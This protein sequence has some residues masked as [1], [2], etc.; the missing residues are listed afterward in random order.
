MKFSISWNQEDLL[1][2]FEEN[3][4]LRR[5][6]STLFWKTKP[7]PL[8]G[9]LCPR[10]D[11]EAAILEHIHKGGFKP[12]EGAVVTWGTRKGLSAQIT[13]VG[14]PEAAPVPKTETSASHVPDEVP[15]PP[16]DLDPSLFPPGTDIAGLKA[17][18]EADQLR[19]PITGEVVGTTKDRQTMTGEE[20]AKE[21]KPNA[22]KKK[23]PVSRRK[24]GKRSR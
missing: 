15:V 20:P 9:I 17:A 10:E 2:L 21:E 7:E 14:D 13:V 23:S 19:H 24:R 4:V 22:P 8:V 5:K 16:M 3:S 6:N 12:A 1:R 18:A 11:L